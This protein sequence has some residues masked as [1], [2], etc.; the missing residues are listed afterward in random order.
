MELQERNE[1][2]EWMS[3]LLENNNKDLIKT[4]E[5]LTMSVEYL[6]VDFN[7]STITWDTRLTNLESKVG[8]LEKQNSLHYPGCP[9]N[10]VIRQLQDAILSRKSVRIWIITS[11]SIVGGVLA[12]ILSTLKLTGQL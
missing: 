2:K 9:N 4:I 5:K 3:L 6:K 10:S 1:M 7:E 8:V 11:I 12:I